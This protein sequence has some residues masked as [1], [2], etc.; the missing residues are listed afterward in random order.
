MSPDVATAIPKLRERGLLTDAQ[1]RRFLR[2]ARG[3]LVSI[4]NELRL[5]LYAGV[6]LITAGVGVL[7]QQN[8]VRLGP[9]AIAI[10][11][12]V[13]AG[14][15]FF[16]IARHAAPFTWEEAP[17]THVAF[18]YVLLLGVLLASADLA[19]VEAQ[20]TPLG[21]NWPWHLLIAS[22]FMALLAFRYDSRVVFSL[23]L[24]T[25]AAWRGVSVAFV[26]GD[27]LWSFGAAT[28]SNAIACGVLFAIL[29]VMLVRAGRKE[30]FEPVATYLG[31]SLVLLSLASGS[32]S[33]EWSWRAYTSLL[34]V[35]GAGLAAYSL[36]FKRRFHLFAM[37]ALAAYVGLS[38]VVVHA[39]DDKTLVFLWF[40]VTSI[41]AIAALIAAHRAVEKAS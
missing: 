35:V 10:A 9:V 33:D 39:I 13:A 32:L 22:L 37:G 28:R 23:A 30:H 16:W 15:C 7:V 41:G 4:H 34:I 40:L 26:G 19:Y 1:A 2:I 20:F 21:P 38:R 11:V 27:L 31:T 29:G 6:L 36:Y 14:A 5:L 3:E 25:F 8:V 12:G 17:S 24:S 18:D